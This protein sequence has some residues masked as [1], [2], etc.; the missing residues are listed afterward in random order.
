MNLVSY[1]DSD[2]SESEQNTSQ[3]QKPAPRTSVSKTS[4]QRVVDRSNPHK[5]K[6]SLPSTSTSTTG[7]DDIYAGGPPAKKAKTAGGGLSGFNAL[8]PAPKKSG[9]SAGPT[10][11]RGLGRGVNLKTGA[12]PA[13][14]REPEENTA[15]YAP[16]NEA[17]EARPSNAEEKAKGK[18]EGEA[19]TENEVKLVGKATRF[20]PLSVAKK[21]QKKRKTTGVGSAA[22]T[23]HVPAQVISSASEIKPP[24]KPKVSLFSIAYDEE[25]K[26]SNSA[27]SAGAYVPLLQDP[28]QGEGAGEE[29]HNIQHDQ[30]HTQ[31][32]YRQREPTISTDSSGAQSLDAIAAD[33]N[34]SA[35]ARRQL[36]GRQGGKLAK[37]FSAVNVINFNTDKEYAHNEELRAKGETVQHNPV[38]AIAPGKHSLQQLVNVASSQREALE[39]HFASG[40]RNKKEAGNKYGW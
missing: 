25:E 22:Q 4:F 23:S 27:E 8:L 29:H 35:A 21:A 32:T 13:F 34:L 17:S 10:A 16:S 28:E 40:R 20:M 30:Q 24:P 33:L 18:G 1:S 9:Q 14:S 11:S 6:V 39:E 3:Q 2:E 37:D 7:E 12:T 38:K 31:G 19:T 26:S 36:F 15:T 5:I